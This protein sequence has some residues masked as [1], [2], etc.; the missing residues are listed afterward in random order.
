[1]SRH[2]VGETWRKRQAFENDANGSKRQVS[3]RH[4]TCQAGSELWFHKWFGLL[5]HLLCL[6]S[7]EYKEEF[8]IQY[9]T[10]LALSYFSKL[11]LP[12]L[13]H[14]HVCCIY[15]SVKEVAWI[16]DRGHNGGF[17]ESTAE[18]RYSANGPHRYEITGLT[19][20]LSRKVKR[21]ERTWSKQL[22]LP[23]P[24]PLFPFSNGLTLRKALTHAFPSAVNKPFLS[25]FL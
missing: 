7:Q 1:M 23:A 19:A 16:S 17:L 20:A 10:Y 18:R 25:F 5:G 14:L 21:G 4:A 22:S 9:H 24:L 11:F 2:G 6:A 8:I 15:I 13:L 3:V 12:F